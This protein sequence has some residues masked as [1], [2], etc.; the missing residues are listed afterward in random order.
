[1]LVVKKEQGLKGGF[2]KFKV[3][4]LIWGKF[5]KPCYLLGTRLKYMIIYYNRTWNSD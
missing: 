2:S 1:M 5:V 3:S 4:V